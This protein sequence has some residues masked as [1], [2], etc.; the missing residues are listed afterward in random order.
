MAKIQ[1][2]SIVNKNDDGAPE[3]TYG[4]SV[5][6]GQTFTAL[7]DVNIVGV[8]TGGNFVGDGSGLTQLSIATKSKAISFKRALGFDEF[9][10]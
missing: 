1:V 8:I 2:N 9:R 4:A 7:G 5:P 6:P 10:S 3:L